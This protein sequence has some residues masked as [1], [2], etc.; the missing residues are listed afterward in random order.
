MAEG[1]FI[2][3]AGRRWETR[4]ILFY[5]HLPNREAPIRTNAGKGIIGQPLYSLFSHFS[6][7]AFPTSWLMSCRTLADNLGHDASNRRRSG[8]K[9]ASSWKSA[10]DSAPPTS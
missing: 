1:V 9:M 7:N 8:G 4:R 2:P 5:D 3:T 6:P 10:P